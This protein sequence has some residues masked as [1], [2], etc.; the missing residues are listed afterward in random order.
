MVLSG[1]ATK[2]KKL[3]WVSLKD[4]LFSLPHRPDSPLLCEILHSPQ[5]TVS[6][7]INTRDSHWLI[8]TSMTQDRDF[9]PVPVVA[10]RFQQNGAVNTVS[11]YSNGS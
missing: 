8:C 1:G 5:R 9:W 11:R 4:L 7:L 10:R 6:V 3:G 2:F